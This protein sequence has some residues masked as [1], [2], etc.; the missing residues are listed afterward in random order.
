[1]HFHVP[2]LADILPFVSCVVVP[3]EV[4]LAN[5]TTEVA[6]R[7]QTGYN[8]PRLTWDSLSLTR[9]LIDLLSTPPPT[10]KDGDSLSSLYYGQRRKDNVV[11][12]M[13]DIFVP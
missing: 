10:H 13:S 2:L 6:N 12:T 9:I 3:T 11:R 1:M 8:R 4:W 7:T 5:P